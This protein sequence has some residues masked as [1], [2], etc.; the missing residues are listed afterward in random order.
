MSSKNAAETARDAARDETALATQYRE[1]GISA[2]A[3]ALQYKPETKNPAYAPAV[4]QPDKWV[5]DL[6]A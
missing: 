3:A 5:A 2:V 4:I 1:I 6:A